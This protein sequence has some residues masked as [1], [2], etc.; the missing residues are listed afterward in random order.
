VPIDE[1]QNWR[2]T[3]LEL[4]FNQTLY[5]PNPITSEHELVLFRAAIP[6][7]LNRHQT[8]RE[9]QL[10]IM[11]NQAPASLVDVLTASGGAE[12]AGK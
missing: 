7:K 5:L 6:T 1:L 12:P 11:A 3:F 2:S 8:E 9:D 10:N 4:L